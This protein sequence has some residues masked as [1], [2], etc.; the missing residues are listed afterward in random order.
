[1]KKYG[2]I[3]LMFLCALVI[4]SC[5]D[6]DETTYEEALAQ[7][8]DWKVENDEAFQAIAANPD[9]TEIKSIGN[10]GSIYI[11][12]LKEGTGREPIYYTDS[13]SVY[14]TVWTVDGE[15]HDAYEPPYNDPIDF[16]VGNTS[17][18]SGWATALQN[19]HVGDR[20]EIWMPQELAYGYIGNYNRNTNIYSILPF[21]TLKYE[22]EVAGIIRNGK[23]IEE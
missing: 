21:S 17:F 2:Y 5:K 4:T 20:W 14:Y 16:P 18:I 9:Y 13:V 10:D 23:V 12:V 7:Y 15:E 22:I 19:M 3:A 11:K 1:M 8:G 6:D